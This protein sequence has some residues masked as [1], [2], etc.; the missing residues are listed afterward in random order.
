MS[1]QA[2]GVVDAGDT[3]LLAA[4]VKM[5]SG[6]LVAEA[7]AARHSN[8]GMNAAATEFEHVDG[9]FVVGATAARNRGE[10]TNA[11]A[12]LNLDEGASTTAAPNLGE[13][14]H[15]AVTCNPSEDTNAAA[16]EENAKGTE[17]MSRS[18]ENKIEKT[19]EGDD[20]IRGLFEERRNTAKGETQQ[21]ER[22]EQEDQT[23]HQRQKKTER[24]ENIQRILEDFRG[25]KSISCK[26]KLEGKE[27]SSRK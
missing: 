9:R 20:E 22:I 24:H 27:S 8:G 1:K 2:E 4:T 10:G 19:R 12:A 6:R 25:I 21:T 3:A 14:T 23:M 13:D 17:V 5:R 16:A 7:A 26:K 18:Q 15:A 11:E